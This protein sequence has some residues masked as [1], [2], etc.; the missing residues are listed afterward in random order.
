MAKFRNRDLKL[1]QGQK[2][3]LGTNVDIQYDGSVLKISG[4]P[5]EAIDSTNIATVSTRGYVDSKI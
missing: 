4:A 2:I 1:K 5:L 3:T